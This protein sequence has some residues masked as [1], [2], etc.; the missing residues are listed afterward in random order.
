MQSLSEMPLPPSNTSLSLCGYTNFPNHLSDDVAN[1]IKKGFSAVK[2]ARI[3]LGNKN[4]IQFLE[5]NKHFCKLL[6]G[7]S[8]VLKITRKIQLLD[9]V[10]LL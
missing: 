1:C 3:D 9:H 2:F 6:S 4:D 8:L 10:Y 5:F 7:D